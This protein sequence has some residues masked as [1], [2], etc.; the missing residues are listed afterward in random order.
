MDSDQDVNCLCNLTFY[1]PVFVCED[2]YISIAKHSK[3][4][5]DLNVQ[6]W[7]RQK[8]RSDSYVTGPYKV[9]NIDCI[10]T[11]LGNWEPGNDHSKWCVTIDQNR[12]WTCIADVNRASTQFKRPGGALCINNVK[13]TNEFKKLVGKT[14][15]CSKK[16]D[17]DSGEE[18]KP[19]CDMDS[20]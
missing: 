8:S 1:P 10:K 11:T 7:G 9:F 12:P 16:M 5:S 19:M 13:I 15:D 3:V 2:L 6:T 18:T 4:R 17:V 20:D 14:Q